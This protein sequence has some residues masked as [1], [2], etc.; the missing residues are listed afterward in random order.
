MG[1]FPND[2][3]SEDCTDGLD[4]TSP[5]QQTTRMVRNQCRFVALIDQAGIPVCAPVWVEFPELSYVASD[6]EFE[7]TAIKIAMADGLLTADRKGSVRARFEPSL[8]AS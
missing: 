6:S 7:S 4:V 5:V 1:A 8:R 2:K 3:Q